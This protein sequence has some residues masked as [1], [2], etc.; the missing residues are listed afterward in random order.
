MNLE[1]IQKLIKIIDESSLDEVMIEE[2]NFKL[3]VKRTSEMSAAQ[4][5]PAAALPPQYL[6]QMGAFPPMV[7]PQYPATA[8]AGTQPS[9]SAET[10]ASK[11]A[12]SGANPHHKEIRS[13]MVGTFYRSPSPEASPYVQVGD[14]V[15]KGKVLCIIEAMKLMNEIESDVE[16]TVVKILIENGQ[17]IEYDQVLFLIDPA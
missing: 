1:D 7:P 2:G 9:A 15:T 10:Q 17:P 3:S 8:S 4:P 14:K 16:G 5:N 12:D 6:P 13:P 11:P